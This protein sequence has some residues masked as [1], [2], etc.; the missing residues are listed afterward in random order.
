M[1][2]KSKVKVYNAF[3]LLCKNVVFFLNI[4]SRQSSRAYSYIITVCSLGSDSIEITVQ[5]H[6]LKNKEAILSLL[7]KTSQQ[8][9][10][11]NVCGLRL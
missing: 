7:K 9:H 5:N 11:E 1:D 10:S 2:E 4:N 6:I 3:A 8:K